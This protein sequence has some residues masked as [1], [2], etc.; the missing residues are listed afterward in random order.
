MADNPIPELK[1]K[2]PLMAADTPMIDELAA[3]GELGTART[4]PIGVAPGSDTGIL[5][6]FGYNP[7]IYY[8]GRS[9]LEAAGSGVSL[10]PGNISYRCNMVA[11]S[12]DDLPFEYKTMLSHSAGSIEGE[13]SIAVLRYL[14]ADTI[15]ADMAAHYKIQFYENPSFRHIAVQKKGHIDGLIVTPPHDILGQEI[16]KFLPQGPGSQI[17]CHLMRRANHVLPNAP[18]NIRR[19]EQRKLQAN[20]IWFWAEGTVAK[21]DSFYDKFAKSGVVISAVPLVIG[22]GTLAGLKHIHVEGATG[23]LDTNYEGKISAALDALKQ[24]NDF[25]VIH[26]EAPDECTHNGDLLGKIKGIEYIDHRVVAPLLEGLNQ[27][28]DDYRILIQADHKTLMA[29]RTHD[30]DPVPYLIYDSRKDLGSGLAYQEDTCEKG[31]RIDDGT[32]LI[33]RLFEM[34]VATN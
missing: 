14:L 17:L 24:G 30:G 7:Q 9:P 27:M 8:T 21:L 19:C 31:H 12:D 15:F 22:I 20:G 25:V 26:V 5:S 23:E 33:A 3:K 28:G 16:E 18:Y 29:T 1:G 10:E 32:K 6:I 2:T 13:H 34:D 4:I 11:L